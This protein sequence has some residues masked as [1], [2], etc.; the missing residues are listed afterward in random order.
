MS[1]PSMLASP[2]L[3]ANVIPDQIYMPDD[4]TE[5]LDALLGDALSIA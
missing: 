3:A 1:T 4:G 2:V 5:T